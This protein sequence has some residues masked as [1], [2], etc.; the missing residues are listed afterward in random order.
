MAKVER[1]VCDGCPKIS[2]D[3]LEDGWLH[4][5]ELRVLEGNLQASYVAGYSLFH[6]GECSDTD[7]KDFC[8]KTCALE[9]QSVALGLAS[10][11]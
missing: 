8:S 7:L 6:W 9:A 11:T 4:G 3:P 2:D 5:Q 10:R 1:Y